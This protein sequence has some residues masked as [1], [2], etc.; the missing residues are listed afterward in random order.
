M[1]G[2]ACAPREIK[3]D[4]WVRTADGATG[5]V[6]YVHRSRDGSDDTVDIAIDNDWEQTVTL[7]RAEVRR[8]PNPANKRPPIDGMPAERAR[9][10]WCERA[11]RPQVI[12]HYDDHPKAWKRLIIR[13]TFAGWRAYE[14]VF[15]STG[16][17]I[18][19]AGASYRG[20]YRRRPS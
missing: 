1:S 16:C 9:C 17:A 12:N 11:L 20:G 3:T 13:R 15:H 18:A 4:H 2:L 6:R 14:G 7:P 8:I 10:A 5:R 19:F